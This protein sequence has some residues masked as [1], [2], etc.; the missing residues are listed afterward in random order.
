MVILLV[1]PHLMEHSI[2]RVSIAPK[3]IG[4]L[5]AFPWLSK[6]PRGNWVG[7]VSARRWACRCQIIR[8]EGE[9]TAIDISHSMYQH[10]FVLFAFPT[11]SAQIVAR[12]TKQM[13]LDLVI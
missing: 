8:R 2:G 4:K 5:A 6:L 13:R 11:R 9:K 10:A 1:S 12:C 3:R 7:H